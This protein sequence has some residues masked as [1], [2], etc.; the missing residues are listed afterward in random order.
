MMLNKRNIPNVVHKF[1]TEHQTPD[2]S[3]ADE[4]KSNAGV[5]ITRPA[6]SDSCMFNDYEDYNEHHE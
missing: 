4:K 2:K 6:I 3:K 1:R 5:D